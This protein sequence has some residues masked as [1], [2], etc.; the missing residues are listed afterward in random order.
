MMLN[1]GITMG[2]IVMVNK[3]ENMATQSINPLL[4]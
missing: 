1:I 2:Y 3:I 4:G